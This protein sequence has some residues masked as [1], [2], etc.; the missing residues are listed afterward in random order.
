VHLHVDT[1]SL[2]HFELL[3]FLVQFFFLLHHI[4]YMSQVQQCGCRH[5]I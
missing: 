1:F 5:K 4:K 2:G 3:L